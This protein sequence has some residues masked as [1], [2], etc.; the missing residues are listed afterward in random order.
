MPNC[1]GK[2]CSVSEE[3]FPGRENLARFPRDIFPGGKT[4]L[5]FRGTLSRAGK[6]CSVSEGHFPG[7]ENL[8]RFPR[9][10]FPSGETLLGFRGTFLQAGKP[11]SVSE[12]HFPKRENLARFQ[13]NISPGGKYLA[14]FYGR[15][16][17]IVCSS[18][19]FPVR[20][21][22]GVCDTPLHFPAKYLHKTAP[23]ITV[24]STNKWEM[25]YAL[26]VSREILTLNDALHCRIP[27]E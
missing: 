23:F 5:G 18:Q 11:C 22:Q 4:L 2:A 19:S 25:R 20:P 6:A 7:R 24:S 12:E 26:T 17:T 27:N 8:A 16:S 3:H 14:A 21:H 1:L 9:D 15:L 13:G 10:I